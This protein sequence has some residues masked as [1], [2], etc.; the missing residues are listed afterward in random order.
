MDYEGHR[1]RLWKSKA[2]SEV[3]EELTAAAAEVKVPRVAVRLP[4]LVVK[5]NIHLQL[6]FSNSLSESS[7]RI[8]HS[9]RSRRT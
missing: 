8:F 9:D 5:K 1:V 4:E 2:V 6:H 7:M 3:V